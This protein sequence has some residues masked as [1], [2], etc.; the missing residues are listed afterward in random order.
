MSTLLAYTGQI[1]KSKLLPVLFWFGIYGLL[2]Y[3]DRNQLPPLENLLSNVVNILTYALLIR[4]NLHFFV[5]L[6]LN[7]SKFWSYI[8]L[9]ILTVILVT[10]ITLFLQT[11]ILK[12]HPE[13]SHNYI[14]GW[15]LLPISYFIILM[16]S[17]MYGV[18]SDWLLK[19]KEIEDLEKTKIQS[20]IRFLKTQINPHFLFNTL[21][22]LYALSLKKSESTPEMLLRLSDIMRYILYE[23]NEDLVDLDKEMEYLSNYI[24]LEKLRY[25]PDIDVKMNIEGDLSGR[26]IP[27]MI[28]ITFVENSFKHGVS[29]SLKS[30][31]IKLDVKIEEPNRFRFRLENSYEKTT[32]KSSKNSG[33]GLENIS[34]RLDLLYPERHHLTTTSTDNVYIVDLWIEL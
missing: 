22:S 24:E 33:I 5:P 21:N 26:K 34:R 27:P 16:G 9:V 17:T 1:Q 7:E 14:S 13:L 28:L 30:P 19:S 8:G 23:C 4:L 18:V 11:N 32:S 15:G 10:P 3:L 20:E 6:Y 2:C 31:Q 25:G 12:N 29:E